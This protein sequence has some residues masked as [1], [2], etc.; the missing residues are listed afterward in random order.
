MR[1]V[2]IKGGFDLAA[3]DGL[4]MPERVHVTHEF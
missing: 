4:R 3:E 2:S 1:F